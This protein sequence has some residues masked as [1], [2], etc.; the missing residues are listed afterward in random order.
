MQRKAKK[1]LLSPKLAAPR[2]RVSLA[3]ADTYD[4]QLALCQ[5]CFLCFCYC[6]RNLLGLHSACLLH[7]HYASDCRF[8]SKFTLQN[9]SL[10]SVTALCAVAN[11]CTR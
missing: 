5:F 10:Y 9:P 1:S 3:R 11:P 4:T 2:V 6:V 8:E 7:P